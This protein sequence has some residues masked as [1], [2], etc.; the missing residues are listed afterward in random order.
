MLFLDSSD[1]DSMRLQ[2]AEDRV[3]RTVRNPMAMAQRQ[4]A[5]GVNQMPIANGAWT[6]DNEWT[7]FWRFGDIMESA[8]LG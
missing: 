6:D 2:R 4:E 3:M 7:D 5:A 8:P 1:V